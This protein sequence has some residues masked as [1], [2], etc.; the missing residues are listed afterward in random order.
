MAPQRQIGRLQSVE[1]GFMWLQA[2]QDRLDVIGPKIASCKVGVEMIQLAEY[3]D[4]F[5]ELIEERTEVQDQM[6]LLV[7]KKRARESRRT[8]QTA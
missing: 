5:H 8:L 2:I 7:G 1:Q 4:E 3:F 6:T